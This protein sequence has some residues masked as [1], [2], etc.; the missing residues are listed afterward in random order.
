MSTMRQI[1]VTVSEENHSDFLQRMEAMPFSVDVVSDEVS[2]EDH[3][4]PEWHKE[5]IIKRMEEPQNFTDWD[6]FLKELDKA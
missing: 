1:L 6:D 3:E 4:V 2:E 5:L